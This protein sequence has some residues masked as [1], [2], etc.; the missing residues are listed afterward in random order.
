VGI[1]SAS[2]GAAGVSADEPP[3]IEHQ[4][5]NCTVPDQRV[6]VCASIFDDQMVSKAR[7]FF[8]PQGERYF[9]YAEMSFNGL[10]YCSV[11]P[12]PRQGKM[13]AL[14]YYLQASDDAFQ[15][16]RGNMNQLVIQESEACP[17]PPVAQETSTPLTVYATHKKQG[18]KLDDKF[19]REGVS[20]I[21]KSR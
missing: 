4:G 5:S 7:V 11:L 3:N 15:T 6:S 10:E 20:F 1:L 18:D 14:E 21:A 13:K 17:F 2:L 19:V 16:R 8:R 12:A 9:N